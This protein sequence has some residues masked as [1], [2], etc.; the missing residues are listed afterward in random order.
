MSHSP[1]KQHLERQDSC[2]GFRQLR[3]VNTIPDHHDCLRPS[4]CALLSESSLVSCDRGVS[5]SSRVVVAGV[6]MIPFTTP[7]NSEPY[8]VMGEAAARRALSDARIEYAS[9]QQAYVGY[10]YG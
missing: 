6:G 10:V 2:S 9:V 8:D 1:L 5:M 4:A 3:T 7:R